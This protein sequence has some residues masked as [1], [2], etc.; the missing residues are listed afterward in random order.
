MFNFFCNI[1]LKKVLQIYLVT[2]LRSIPKSPV[3]KSQA[4]HFAAFF[5]FLTAFLLILLEGLLIVIALGTVS[6]LMC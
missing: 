5:S 6:Y 3:S 4:K 2:V 1:F